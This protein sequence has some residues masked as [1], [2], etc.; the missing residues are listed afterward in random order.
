VVAVDEE[1]VRQ[2]QKELEEAEE[3][4]G[5]QMK[6]AKTVLKRLREEKKSCMTLVVVEEAEEKKLKKEKE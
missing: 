3:Q 4:L 5:T 2:L 6:R 1:Q